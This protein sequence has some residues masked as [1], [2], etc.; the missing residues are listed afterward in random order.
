MTLSTEQKIMNAI[1]PG[2]GA[3]L[4]VYETLPDIYRL[5]ATGDEWASEMRSEIGVSNPKSLR[6]VTGADPLLP[7]VDNPARGTN[8]VINTVTFAQRLLSV[9]EAMVFDTIN[10]Q[11]WIEDFPEFKPTGNLID[12]RLA[13]SI[14]DAVFTILGNR[15]KN[16]ISRNLVKGGTTAQTSGTLTTGV[17]YIIKTFVAGDDFSNVDGTPLVGSA[18]TT[19]CIFTA[20]GTTPTAWTNGSELQE[21]STSF[22]D[23]LEVLIDAD[24]D[25]IDVSNVGV[26]TA[27]N[28][29]SILEDFVAAI[30]AEI[31][32]NPDFKIFVPKSVWNLTMEANRATQQNGTLLTTGNVPM[33]FGKYPFLKKNSMS[34]NRIIG[35]IAGTGTESNLVRGYWFENDEESFL[36]YK[37]NPGNKD[38]QILL[39]F[40]MGM[41]YRSGSHIVSYK[42]V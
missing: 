34:D 15:V 20:A 11:D 41:Q 16:Q 8:D 9:T 23:G 4:H 7:A 26:I 30:P 12:L 10:P 1:T 42:G 39:R 40:F 33:I 6:S 18:N 14:Q 21:L 24:S 31:D 35:T 22:I 17:T 13:S 38:W 32:D 28:V 29:L 3:A 25:V 37:E 5:I 36:M 27:S 2:A 19:G